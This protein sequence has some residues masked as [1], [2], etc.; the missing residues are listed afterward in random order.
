MTVFARE[1]HNCQFRIGNRGCL[2]ERIFAFLEFDH[3]GLRPLY[4]G[5]ARCAIL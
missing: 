2:Q 1:P 4:S 5:S 3:G